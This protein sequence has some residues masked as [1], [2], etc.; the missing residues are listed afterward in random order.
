MSSG[1][2]A[3]TRRVFDMNEGAIISVGVSVDGGE[4]VRVS[5]TL[6]EVPAG[7]RPFLTE[8]TALVM[9]MQAHVMTPGAA[10]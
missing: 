6:G 8:M 4:T 7:L 2:T 10:P 1:H 5:F 3:N 9:A